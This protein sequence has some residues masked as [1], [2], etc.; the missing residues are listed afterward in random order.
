LIEDTLAYLQMLELQAKNN[1]DKFH[2]RFRLWIYLGPS[3]SHMS[4]LHLIL[5]H[6]TGQVSPQ[7]HLEFHDEFDMERDGCQ[8]KKVKSEWREKAGLCPKKATI[9]PEVTALEEIASGHRPMR[10]VGHKNKIAAQ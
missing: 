7:W 1:I 6:A 3:P 4:T 5:S 2:Q 8:L 9:G 10:F